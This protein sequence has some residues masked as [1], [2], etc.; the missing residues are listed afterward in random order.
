MY[1]TTLKQ[2]IHEATLWC[3]QLLPTTKLPCV[4]QV[5]AQLHVAGNSCL[6]IDSKSN[7]NNVARNSCQQQCCS[8]SGQ[9]ML[10]QFLGLENHQHLA[11]LYLCYHSHANANWSLLQAITIIGLVFTKT[12]TYKCKKCTL[13]L[14]ETK[15]RGR[16]DKMA[17]CITIIIQVAGVWVDI[18]STKGVLV[19]QPITNH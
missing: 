5:V 8:M 3:W 17:H 16:Q 9:L 14:S 2:A 11:A 15:S 10:H 18:M 13:K 1:T 19:L 6:W 7:C 4:W 12:Y